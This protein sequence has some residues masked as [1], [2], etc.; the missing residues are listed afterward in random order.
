MSNFIIPLLIILALGAF[1]AYKKGKFGGGAIVV[2]PVP[3]QGLYFPGIYQGRVD[4]PDHDERI[5]SRNRSIIEA[6]GVV[7][8]D[9][10]IDNVTSMGGGVDG[11]QYL[12]GGYG[13]ETDASGNV[14]AG[15]FII[16]GSKMA[17]SGG[18]VKADGTFE[19]NAS[20]LPVFGKVTGV[21]ISGRA[22]EPGRD[23]V[24]GYLEGHFTL[25]GHL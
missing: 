21:S 22:E 1:Y 3:A 6:G 14:I 11:G 18:Q 15:E 10:A 4:P 7:T 16:H 24:R 13:F 9:D 23:Y 19:F 25:G 5:A 17:V 2:P 20:G 12:Q 8:G